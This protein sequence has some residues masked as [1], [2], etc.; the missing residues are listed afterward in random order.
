MD[1]HSS[2]FF[3]ALINKDVTLLFEETNVLESK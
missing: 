1:K 3:I 2:L